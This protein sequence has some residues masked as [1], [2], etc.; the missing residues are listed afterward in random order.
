MPL[1]NIFL[2]PRQWFRCFHYHPR[3]KMHGL[4]VW[5]PR[6]DT[7]RPM[8]GCLVRAL[9]S[10]IS[11]L[12]VLTAASSPAETESVETEVRATLAQFI[13]AFDNL[14]WDA[15]RSAFDDDAAVF[16]PRGVPERANGRAEFERTFRIVFEQIRQ[17]KTAAPFMDIQP[18]DLK[19]QIF[20][21]I[22]IATFDLD[23]RPGFA[24]RRTIVLHRAGRGWKIVHLHASEV[25]NGNTKQER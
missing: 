5:F 17:G 16:Y 15:F 22:A 13:T 6:D 23:D 21:E 3:A 14:D 12:L 25:S 7:L 20:G 24:N 8:K 1:V 10:L 9:L 19:L 18:R 4:T 2:H 11:L